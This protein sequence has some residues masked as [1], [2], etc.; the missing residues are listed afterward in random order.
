MRR[1]EVLNMDKIGR[2]LKEMISCSKYTYEDIA[3]VLNLASPRVIYDWV[4][5]IKLPSV[6]NLVVISRLFNVHLEDILFVED[7]F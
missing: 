6:S 1:D 3:E 2:K 5:G 4:N 7:V